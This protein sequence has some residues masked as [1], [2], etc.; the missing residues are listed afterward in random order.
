MEN[1]LLAQKLDSNY[2]GAWNTHTHAHQLICSTY[3]LSP[4]SSDLYIGQADGLVQHLDALEPT[5]SQSY[6]IKD[7]SVRELEIWFSQSLLVVAGDKELHFLDLKNLEKISYSAE[8]QLEL[9]PDNKHV[10]CFGEFITFCS[11]ENTIVGYVGCG[12]IKNGVN[13]EQAFK[14]TLEVKPLQW[15]LWNKEIIVLESKGEISIY[16]HQ[17]NVTELKFKCEPNIMLMYKNPSYMFRD[18]VFCSTSAAVGLIVRTS[19][20]LLGWRLDQSEG[21]LHRALEQ[22]KINP[23]D[24]VWCVALRRNIIACGTEE[25]CIVFFS[26]NQSEDVHDPPD[27]MLPFKKGHSVV[28]LEFDCNKT[29]AFK[30]KVSSRPILAIDVSFVDDKILLFYRTDIQN[31]SCLILHNK[32]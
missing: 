14:I 16:S 12:T 22:D 13:L 18:V 31:M 29:P 30:K 3:T 8:T 27:P 21:R 9:C 17:Q 10:S 1:N 4:S 11:D 5:F 26:N 15:K 6:N 28:Q 19:Y 25:G 20:W 23:E 32:R 2:L 7:G 24:E